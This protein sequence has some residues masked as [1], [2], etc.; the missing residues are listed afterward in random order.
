M[1][2]VVVS[3]KFQVVIPV[4]VRRHQGIRPG[5]RLAVLVEHGVVHLVRV[6]PFGASKGRFKGAK[7]DL[8]DLPDHADRR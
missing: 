3:S 8:R 2:T 7:V 1:E 6:R 4:R 5:D